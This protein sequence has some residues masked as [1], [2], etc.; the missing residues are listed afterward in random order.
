MDR[1][2]PS[3]GTLTKNVV[4]SRQW[5]GMQASTALSPESSVMNTS[6]IGVVLKASKLANVRVSRSKR[7][8]LVTTKV[9]LLSLEKIN[10]QTSRKPWGVMLQV[11]CTASEA[12]PSSSFSL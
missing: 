11:S 2:C 1:S 9:T 10:I 12:S 3:R 5:W 7:P 4:C 8:Q 6:R